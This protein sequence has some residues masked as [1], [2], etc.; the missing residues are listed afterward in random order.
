M[1]GETMHGNGGRT[2]N[3]RTEETQLAIFRAAGCHCDTDTY[4]CCWRGAD[5]M[6]VAYTAGV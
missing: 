4:D 6:A 5:Y 1:N 2:L 3:D